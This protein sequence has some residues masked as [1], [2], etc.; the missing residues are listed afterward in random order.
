MTA[1]AKQ[2]KR[3]QA[4][5][6]SLEPD[7]QNILSEIEG[8]AANTEPGVTLAEVVV[9]NDHVNDLRGGE[10][11]PLENR[12][13]LI[14]LGNVDISALNWPTVQSL[15]DGVGLYH[16][17]GGWRFAIRLS[18]YFSEEIGAYIRDKEGV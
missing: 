11:F 15:F 7:Q 18:D 5:R 13:F 1:T 4:V 8:R 2:W 6:A 16:A 12:R 17:H 3:Y 9:F 10:Y 14:E